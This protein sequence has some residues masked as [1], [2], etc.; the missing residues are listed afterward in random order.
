MPTV[1]LTDPQTVTEAELTTLYDAVGWSAYTREPAM[2]LAAVRGSHRVA[3]AR[4]EGVLVGL[5]RT[6]SDAVTIVYLQDVLVHPHWQRRGLG[7]RLVQEVLAADPHVRQRV[8]LTDADPAQRA[9][10]TALGFTETHDHDP[11]LRAFVQ[12]TV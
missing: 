11:E 2:L 8:L 9:F 7:R 12:L 6:I 1:Q 5:A 10:Y 3:L 4:A